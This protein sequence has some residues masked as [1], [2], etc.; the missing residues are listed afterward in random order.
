MRKRRIIIFMKKLIKQLS[1]A[2]MA[3]AAFCL[4]PSFSQAQMTGGYSDVSKTDKAV[5]AA[6]NFA[7]KTQSKKGAALKL[8]SI[9]SAQRQVVAGSNY[10]MCL[11]VNSAKKRREAVAVVYQNLQNQLKLTSWTPGK[12]SV[13]VADIAA[14]EQIVKNLYAAQKAAT[15]VFFQH[16]SRAAVD[17]F[18]E[19]SFA[20]LIWKDT[21][22]AKGE[23]GAIDFDPLYNAQDTRVAAFKIGAPEYGEGNADLA[24]VPV[25]FVNM[26][27]AETVLFRFER[28]AGG[29]KAWKISD[30]FY[31]SNSEDAASL[32]KI[33]LH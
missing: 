2:A 3:F 10:Q 20:D 16:K 18:F 4:A 32:K 27:K 17:R 8:V 12:C 31:P 13:A 25:T 19:K 22:V 6:A 33:L 9:A 30:I 14:P 15:G 23:V 7:V 5:V 11:V 29:G 26:G 28:A 21:E 24:D 1:A